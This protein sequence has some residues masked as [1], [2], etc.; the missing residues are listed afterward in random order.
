[1]FRSKSKLTMTVVDCFMDK[2][3]RYTMNIMSAANSR[4]VGDFAVFMN[5]ALLHSC[6]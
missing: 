3:V 5:V 1:M 4:N 2:Q 6:S